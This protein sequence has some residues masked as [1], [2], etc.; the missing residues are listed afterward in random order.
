MKVTHQ[1][2]EYKPEL[3]KSRYVRF[4]KFDGIF[5]FCEVGKDRRFDIRQG[6]VDESELP[7]AVAIKARENCNIFPSYVEWPL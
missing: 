1:S 2:K 3:V 5:Y 4:C 6:S 7:K